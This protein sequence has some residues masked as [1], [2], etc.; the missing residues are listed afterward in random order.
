MQPSSTTELTPGTRLCA[1][2]SQQY[3]CLYPGSVAELGSPNSEVDSKYVFVEFDDGD[4][5]K[6][7]LEDIRLLPPDYPI[8]GSLLIFSRFS[9]LKAVLVLE[10]DP[11]PLQS[12][13]KRRRRTSTSVS[14]E[15]RRPSL[16]E[17]STVEPELPTVKENKEQIDPDVYRERKRL[18]KRKRDKL[19]Q[20]LLHTDKKKKKKHKCESSDCKHR[21]HHKKHRKH[22]KH[23]HSK[24]VVEKEEDKVE[25]LNGGAE[26]EEENSTE[27]N[28]SEE[29][30]N[31]EDEV[32]MDDIIESNNKK[33]K[34]KKIRD[35]QES[36][37]SRSKM[38]A[39]LP[40]RQL[41]RWSGKGYKRP[42]AKGRSRKQFF[43]AIQRD[44]ESIMVGDSA[45]FLSTGRPDRPYIGRIEAMWETCGTMVVKVKWFYHPEET[46][47]CPLNLQYPVSLLK[48]QS[49]S[50]NNHCF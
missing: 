39:F 6:I 11:N 26:E 7:A 2:W 47:G 1:Y 24:E 37:E 15:E 22:K 40:A 33:D 27:T 30:P 31:P 12:L 43:K 17:P 46:V 25:V 32:T 35:R 19:K 38:S 44:K 10:Y 45:V 5:G 42:R 9:A 49:Y 13:S 18:K 48:K 20:K 23:H 28:E 29:L 50:E 21:K 16:P 3:R 14:T 36:C 41:W 34:S 8:I 4:S